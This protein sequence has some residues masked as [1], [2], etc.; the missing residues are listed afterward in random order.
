MQS[1]GQGRAKGGE[2]YPE[3]GMPDFSLKRGG[4]LVASSIAKEGTARAGGLEAVRLLKLERMRKWDGAFAFARVCPRL[5]AL[6]WG[7]GRSAGSLVFGGANARTGG[8]TPPST[9]GRM[10]DATFGG[11]RFGSVYA[12]LERF[13]T[14]GVGLGVGLGMRIG[15]QNG[16]SVGLV[17]LRRF[18][19]TGAGKCGMGSAECG[20]QI[21]VHI[22]GGSSAS[23][24]LGPLLP[25]FARL[26]GAEE[27]I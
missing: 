12:G 13:T 23:A 18:T 4:R 1:L 5:P 21:R 2:R 27:N 20:I 16:K 6:Y 19:L 14:R 8:G 3:Q 25:A 15:A 26:A 7:G 22:G 24:R 11:R 17:G 10:P 9:S